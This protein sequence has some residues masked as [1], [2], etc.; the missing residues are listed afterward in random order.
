MRKCL[1]L[2][3]LVILPCAA[4]ADPFVQLP[5]LAGTVC[6]PDGTDEESAVY[7]YHYAY[8]QVAGDGETEA[9]INEYYTYEVENALAFT[10]P[11]RGE[12]IMDPSVQAVPTVYYR[13]TANNAQFFSVVIVTDTTA[14]GERVVTV[15][16]QTFSRATDKPG[17]VMTLPFLVDMLEDSVEDD[18]LRDRQTAQASTV[19]RDLIWEEIE[20]RRAQGEVFPDSWTREMLDYEFYPE[21]DFF[22]SDADGMLVFFFQPY[23]NAEGMDPASYYTF[24][25]DADDIVDEM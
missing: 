17:N 18:W 22:Y 24:A 19:V 25:I 13:V 9:T 16:A 2:M 3:L 15:G 1:L 4:L 10:V 8:P 11:I 23:L 5:D 14:D 21:E 20:D 6:W 12:E 7:L